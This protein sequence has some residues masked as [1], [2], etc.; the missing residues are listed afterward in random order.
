MPTDKNQP[1]VEL[2]NY[3]MHKAIVQKMDG[4]HWIQLDSIG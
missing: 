1:L 4:D 3:D 2:P